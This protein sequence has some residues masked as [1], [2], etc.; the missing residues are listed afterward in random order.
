MKKWGKRGFEQFLEL[1]RE[2]GG[3]NWGGAFFEIYGGVS[4]VWEIQGK[5]IMERVRRFL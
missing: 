4:W 2:G 3:G 1:L 5:I